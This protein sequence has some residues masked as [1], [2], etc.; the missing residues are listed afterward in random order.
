ML[1]YGVIVSEHNSGSGEWMRV[2]MRGP[3]GKDNALNLRRLGRSR[4]MTGFA[5]S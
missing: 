5:L 2:C 4:L 1:S 3:E